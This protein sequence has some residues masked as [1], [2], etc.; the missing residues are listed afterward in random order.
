MALSLHAEYLLGYLAGAKNLAARDVVPFARL[1]SSARTPQS[2][3][4]VNALALGVSDGRRGRAVR[5]ASEVRMRVLT[6]MNPRAVTGSHAVVSPSD[7][8]V[9][10]VLAEHRDSDPNLALDA[11]LARIAVGE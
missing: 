8:E 9:A 11:I 1:D 3:A 5:D 6:M 7:S 4:L 2:S 10:A